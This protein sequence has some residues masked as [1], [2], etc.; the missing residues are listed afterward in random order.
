MASRLKPGAE[1]LLSAALALPP[2]Q[3][4][5]IAERLLRSLDGTGYVALSPAW[6]AEIDRRLKEIDDGTAEMVDGDEFLEWLRSKY[7]RP[8]EKRT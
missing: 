6:Q 3:R 8:A 7:V 2:E 4:E 1:Q 5:E